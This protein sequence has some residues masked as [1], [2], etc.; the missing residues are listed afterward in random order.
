MSYQPEDGEL[1]YCGICNRTQLPE[2]GEKC[3]ICGKQTISWYTKRESQ[4]EVISRW[5]YING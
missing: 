5:Q 3:V 4:S 1:F 2:K